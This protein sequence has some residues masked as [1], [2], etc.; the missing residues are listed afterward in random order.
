MSDLVRMRLKFNEFGI[1]E[2]TTFAI[3]KDGDRVVVEF[4]DL[5]CWLAVSSEDDIYVLGRYEEINSY[6]Q[7]CYKMFSENTLDL[8]IR[9]YILHHINER[10]DHNSLIKEDWRK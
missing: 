2:N 1:V 7:H 9:R 6:A 10:L 4:G 8:G 5:Q 3:N